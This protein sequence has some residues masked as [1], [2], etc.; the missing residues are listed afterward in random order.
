MKA[1]LAGAA[2]GGQNIDE[3][4]ALELISQGEALLVEASTCAGNIP[5]CAQ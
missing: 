5:A 2:F 1:M 3:L 4:H